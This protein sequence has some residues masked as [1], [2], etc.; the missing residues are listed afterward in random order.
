[1]RI[2]I[3]NDDEIVFESD[4]KTVLMPSDQAQRS[5]VF[6]ALM[7]SLALLCRVPQIHEIP[8]DVADPGALAQ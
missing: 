4:G 8:D 1:M 3:H 5:F 2:T 6:Y 7:G